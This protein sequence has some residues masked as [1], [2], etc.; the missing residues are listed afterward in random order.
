MNAWGLAKDEFTTNGNFPTQMYVR[1]ARRM[2]SDYVM[3]E[4]DCRWERKC[5]DPVG[6][7]A[8]NMDSH[9]CQRIAQG[10]FARNEGDVQVGV[11]GPYPVSYRSII[12]KAEQ[13]TNLLVPVCLAASHI[14]Y[15]SIRMEPVF[16]SMG[17]SAATAAALAIDRKS[18]VQK[19]DYAKLRQRLETDAQILEWT[20]PTKRAATGI[21]P[22]SLPGLVLDDTQAELKGE[23]TQS[24]V[25]R[26]LGTAYHHDANAGKGACTA[27]FRPDIR[28]A[29][30]YEL[31]LL[32]PSHENR[33]SNV[34]V[35]IA[36]DGAATKTVT[37]NQKKAGPN[38]EASLGTFRLPVGKSV[39]ITIS[40]A[41]TDGYVI[42]DGLQLVKK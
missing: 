6:L 19:V 4:A 24:S 20:G 36:I 23:W 18:T 21:D 28:E 27:T 32:Y 3:T 35:A 2:I 41:A 10:G 38:S 42:V 5:D 30:E 39:T 26:S 40:N 29:G 11:S 15:G 22:K 16:M 33:A 17:Q 7:G 37:I 25:V 13:A 9:N 31:L 8:Y 34:P 12:P 1:E 14:A